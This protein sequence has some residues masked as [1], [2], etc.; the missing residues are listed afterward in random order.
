[1]EGEGNEIGVEPRALTLLLSKIT[2][3]SSSG[4]SGGRSAGSQLRISV[5]EIYLERVRDLLDDR[6]GTSK[7]RHTPPAIP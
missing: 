5:M 2:L 3:S 6:C 1:M 7:L 4:A